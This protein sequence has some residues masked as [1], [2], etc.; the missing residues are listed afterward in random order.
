METLRN[1]GFFCFVHLLLFPSGCHRLSQRILYE[2]YQE[3]LFIVEYGLGAV[4]TP[5]DKGYVKDD[6]RIEYLR[7]QIKAFKESVLGFG[8]N[9]NRLKAISRRERP[10][11]PGAAALNGYVCR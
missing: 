7:E 8:I 4:D 10:M 9:Y 3:P 11:R 2:R 5:V 6:Y 1:Q